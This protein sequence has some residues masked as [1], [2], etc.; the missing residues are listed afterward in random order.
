MS[1]SRS[2]VDIR[3][4]GRLKPQYIISAH[5]GDV[6][7]PSEHRDTSALER[8]I[9]E[10]DPNEIYIRWP[11]QREAELK[12]VLLA[13]EGLGFQREDSWPVLPQVSTKDDDLVV[14]VARPQPMHPP[15]LALPFRQK[16]PEYT[17][18]EG[19]HRLIAALQS[20]IESSA[21]HAILSSAFDAQYSVRHIMT[22]GSTSRGTYA[23]FP[24]DFDLVVDTERER[25]S[26]E[27]AVAKLACEKLVERVTQSKAF[28][29]YW[30]AI[31]LSAGRPSL[32]RPCVELQSLGARGPQSLV[33]RYDLVW[34]N[35]AMEDR[36]TLLDVTFGKLPQLIG[37]EI[38]FRRFLKNLSPPWAERVRS[39]IRAAKTILKQIGEVYGSANHGLRGHAAEQWIIQSFNYRAP[40]I[41]V[42]TLDNALRLIVEEGATAISREA[43]AP[44]PFEDFKTRFP[45]WHP[46]WW[47]GELGLGD[48]RRNVNLWDLLGDS[49]AAA[50]EHKWQKLVALGLAYIRGEKCPGMLSQR[51]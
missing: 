34:R 35:T 40:G 49:D 6:E 32:G 29:N 8:A 11:R 41:P 20:E 1:L 25:T 47:E 15:Q 13:L 10:G 31:V 7:C 9:A 37:Y 26:I 16:W 2:E 14:R 28:E 43:I 12:H 51:A 17:V 23:A 27:L 46:G 39:E 45:L 42:G 24:V 4:T 44:L 19:H 18:A 5:N 3:G 36:V 48:D 50:A 33:A 21:G 30:R 38:W 22:V